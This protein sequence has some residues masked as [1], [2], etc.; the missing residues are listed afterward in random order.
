MKA[1]IIVYNDTIPA[2]HVR[3][4]WHCCLR[5]PGEDPMAAASS[6]YQLCFRLGSEGLIS[7]CAGE[8]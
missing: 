5:D 7:L 3:V 8:S 4:V 2:R 6:L 1:V